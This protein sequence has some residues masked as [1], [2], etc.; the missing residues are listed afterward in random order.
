MQLKLACK[1]T[2]EGLLER[3]VGAHLQIV[4]YLHLYPEKL[5]SL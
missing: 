1:A 3:R 5:P 2:A 4:I